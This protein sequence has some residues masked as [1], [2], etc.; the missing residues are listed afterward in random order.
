MVLH[1]MLSLW[2]AWLAKDLFGVETVFDAV[3]SWGAETGNQAGFN[4][5]TTKKYVFCP[6]SLMKSTCGP[7]GLQ[8]GQ[9]CSLQ[10]YWKHL[11]WEFRQKPRENFREGYRPSLA[12]DG[13][14]RDFS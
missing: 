7:K 11:T 3:C 6:T 5:A 8:T 13:Q 12:S 2:S 4:S 10:C 9:L 14:G 1:F